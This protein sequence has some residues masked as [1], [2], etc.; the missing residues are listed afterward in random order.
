MISVFTL[1]NILIF[2]NIIAAVIEDKISKFLF[3]KCVYQ[4]GSLLH[5]FVP[6]RSSQYQKVW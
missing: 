1:M 6:R 2:I 5:V 3:Q 4:T